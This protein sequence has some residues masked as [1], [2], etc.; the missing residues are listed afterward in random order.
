MNKLLINFLVILLASTVALAQQVSGTVTE[1]DSGAPLPG[2][3]VVVKGTNIGTTTDFDGVF[4]L[5]GVSGDATLVISYI[6]FDT[7]EVAVFN[8]IKTM[9]NT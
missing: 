7:Q 3:T 8:A 1:A 9:M 6:G 5:S 2:A 4:Q